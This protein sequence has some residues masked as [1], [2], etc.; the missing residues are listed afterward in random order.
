M[1]TSPFHSD[2]SSI[3]AWRQRAACIAR[4]MNRDFTW[5]AAACIML[6]AL[7]LRLAGAG[8]TAPIGKQ[9]IDGMAPA[10]LV[11][12]ATAADEA[13]PSAAAAASCSPQRDAALQSHFMLLHLCS[14]ERPE[15]DDVQA[16]LPKKRGR[17][18]RQRMT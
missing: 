4:A 9:S 6:A 1:P 7:C 8:D 11:T 13:A 12:P 2:P 10:A 17:A 16:E 3:A 5:L 18:I 15:G 14:V